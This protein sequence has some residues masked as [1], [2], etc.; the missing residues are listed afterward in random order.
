MV[1]A[2]RLADGTSLRFELGTPVWKDRECVC[3]VFVSKFDQDVPIR[4]VDPLNAVS[5]AIMFI[6]AHLATLTPRVVSWD[7]GEPFLR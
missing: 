5:S 3:N 7:T 4:G 2:F 1:F 6:E